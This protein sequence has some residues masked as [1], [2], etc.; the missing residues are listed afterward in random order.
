M[1]AIQPPSYLQNGSHSARSDRIT[2][3]ALWTPGS[4]PLSVRGGIRASGT[5]ADFAVTA[6]NTGIVTVG[7]GTAVIPAVSGGAYLCHNDAG[8]G[9]TAIPAHPTLT[10]IDLLIARV[11]DTEAGSAQDQWSFEFVQ[12]VASGS[13]TPPSAPA[14]SVPLA[15]VRIRPGGSTAVIASDI[16]DRRGARAVAA[17]GVIP[18]T[19]ATLPS[20][21]PVGTPAWAEDIRSLMVY[22]PTGWRKVRTV[23]QADTGE[24]SSYAP[25]VTAATNPVLGFNAERLGRYRILDGRTVHFGI[26]V[27]IGGT[28]YNGGV[29][30][31]SISLP[32]MSA[33]GATAVPHLCQVIAFDFSD[34][35]NHIG[36]GKIYRGSSVVSSIVFPSGVSA[37]LNKA[38]PFTFSTSDLIYVTGTYEAD[39]TAL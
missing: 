33:A 29:G 30:N 1:T 19:T 7:A 35:A 21:V 26:F 4:A 34:E 38:W 2:M 8:V 20:S 25:V 24:W 3:G 14:L 12:G 39:A 22:D 28:G 27:S 10:R 32:V 18:V 11:Y 36:I 16:V 13:P 17:G 31:W 23:A 6:N 5:G 15:E 37:G 9:V